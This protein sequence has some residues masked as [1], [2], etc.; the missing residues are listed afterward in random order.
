MKR[1]I[2]FFATV[3]TIISCT[4]IQKPKETPTSTPLEFYSNGNI[5]NVVFQD[6]QTNEGFAWYVLH[7]ND[8]RKKKQ[9]K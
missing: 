9:T 5:N 2:L 7:N 8:Y 1:L 6:I 4:D 3:I